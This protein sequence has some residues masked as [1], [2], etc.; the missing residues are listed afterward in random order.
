MAEMGG[1]PKSLG[2]TYTY[3]DPGMLIS[4]AIWGQLESSHITGV[5]I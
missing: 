3:R 1:V 2:G 5:P 4:L